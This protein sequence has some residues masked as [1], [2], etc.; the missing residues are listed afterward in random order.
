MR[1]P[2]PEKSPVNPWPLSAIIRSLGRGVAQPGSALAWGARGRKFES[3][4]PDQLKKQEL[5]SVFVTFKKLKNSQFGDSTGD[6]LAFSRCTWREGFLRN[7]ATP[8]KLRIRDAQTPGLNVPSHRSALP[9]RRFVSRV[10]HRRCP[11]RSRLGQSQG[12]RDQRSSGARERP[13]VQPPSPSLRGQR[14]Q[15][16]PLQGGQPMREC[17]EK[18]AT[19]KPLFSRQ[20]QFQ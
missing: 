13:Q 17:G 4:R 11:G 15:R 3:C 2:R 7:G 8:A 5:T 9:K 6:S 16:G 10:H 18:R 20:H 12:S 19:N 14:R 1:P